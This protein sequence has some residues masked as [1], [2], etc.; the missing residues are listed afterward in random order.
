MADTVFDQSSRRA[1]RL[2]PPGFFAWLLTNF[3][4]VL[5]FGRWL[6][7]RSTPSPGGREPTADT[8]AE[9]HELAAAAPPWLFLLEFQTE[10]DANMFGRLLVQLGEAWQ[11]LHPD[12]ERGSR[13]QLGDGVVNL[14]GTSESMPASH[15]YQLPGGDGLVCGA[16]FRERYLAEE[17]ADQTLRRLESGELSRVVLVFVPLTQDGGEDAIIRRWLDVAS[18]EADSRLRAE[19]ASLALVMAEQKDWFPAWNQAL[20]EWNMRESQVVKEWKLE[21]KQEGKLEGRIE[22]L[23]EMLRFLLQDRFGAVPEEW[24]AR[25]EAA[26][27]PERLQQAVRQVPKLT[28]LEDLAF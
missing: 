13:Y 21:G 22:T 9:L 26:A 27:D 7:T 15:L 18:Q 16:R 3:A 23:R 28:R 12:P 2:D 5:R 20:K 14:T 10:P 4:A 19:Y 6:D 1:V 25:I 17:S 8:V 11:H 24:S